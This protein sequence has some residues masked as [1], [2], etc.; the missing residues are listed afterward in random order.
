MGTSFRRGWNEPST[1]FPNYYT[2]AKLMRQRHLTRN[3]YDWTWFQR[4]MNYAGFERQLGSYTPQTPL[5]MLPFVPLTGLRP[6]N[7]RRVWLAVN[8]VLLAAVVLMLVRV[9]G[10]PWDPIVILLL[11]G[12]SSMAGN[13][14]LGQ[15]YVFL[16]FLITLTLYL[17]DRGAFRAS[18][19][20]CGIAFGLK[21]YTGPLLLFFA[22]K[23]RWGSVLG[24]LAGIAVFGAFAIAWLGWSD[25]TYYLTRV[26]PRTL[27]GG[28]IDPYNPGV[29][30]VSTM[31]RRLFMREPALNP[32]PA[33]DAPWLFF[34]S[35]TAIQLGLIV[36]TTL[37]I[38]LSKDTDHRRGFAWFV[39]ALILLSTS[40]ASYT[41]ILLLTPVVLLV[42]DSR[43]WTA[44]YLLL[45]YIL[46][47]ANLQPAWLFPK[48][49]LL[50]LLYAMVGAEILHSVRPF[51]VLSAGA[52]IVLVSL[53]DMQVHIEAYDREPGRKYQQI[54]AAGKE[55]LF[56]GYP[57]VL[58]AGLFYQAFGDFR[59]GE[60]YVLGW[61]NDSQAEIFEFDGHVLQPFA[62]VPKNKIYFELARHGNSTIMEF[63]PLTRIAIPSTAH[64]IQQDR[65]VVTSPNGKWVAYTQLSAASQSLWVRNQTSGKAMQVAG[66]T[67][68]NSSPVWELDSSAIIFSSDCGRAFG[69]PALYRAPAADFGSESAQHS[70]RKRADH[71][72]PS[73]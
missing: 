44:V 42:K 72:N 35:R 30:T 10:L 1:D 60:G 33:V 13:F 22:A 23:R 48:V 71:R 26:L 46:L 50:F 34:F 8:L 12:H 11:C 45:S 66:G 32:S 27:D 67:C 47:N 18:G 62:D 17:F 73:Q 61:L 5:T 65:S 28:S 4:Q 59:R 41:F 69:L 24:M 15:Y 55:S 6:Q 51:W 37:G 31:L 63:N 39:I 40:V 25:I 58:P 49:W 56:L 36:F 19:V 20:L 7:A 43:P 9:S 70:S 38:A 53:I 16:L 14:V 64:A 29:P 54:A 57:A 3:Y 21:L 68:N 2:A 52:I